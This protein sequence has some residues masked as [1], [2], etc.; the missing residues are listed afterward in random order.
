MQS[1]EIPLPDGLR[2]HVERAGDGPPLVL[3][4]GFTGSTETWTP[5]AVT[6]DRFST[7][8]VDLPGHGRSSAP[9]DPTRY[10]LP[11]FADDLAAV[12][13]A[14]N[15]DRAAVLG[16]SLGARAAMHFALGHPKRLAALVLESAS[17]GIGDDDERAA[18]LASDAALADTIERDGVP[19]FVDQWERLP[20]WASQKTLS[21][22]T[23]SQLRE[24]R[25]AN[26]PR[27]LA[28]SLRGAGA[29]AEPSMLHRV[30]EIGIPTL[31]V[32]G[33]LD[34]KYTA[35]ARLLEARLPDA[36]LALVPD[37]GHAV[38]LERP[39]VL[40]DLV[41]SFLDEV[42]SARGAWG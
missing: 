16:Y 23:R 21:S 24:Q 28:N 15:V 13:D 37:V 22:E 1:R 31:L 27:G 2:L 6:L 30:G 20:L 5:L 7:I 25:L 4:H 33:A 17:P 32:A 14:L 8:A 36:R 3:L 42:R 41:A 26:D 39:A 40:A 29:G 9:A 34:M 10:A 35:L 12:L 11:R 18:R 38:H 19:A